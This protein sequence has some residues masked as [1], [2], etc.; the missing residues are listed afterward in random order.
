MAE[1][2]RGGEL[3]RLEECPLQVCR[4]KEHIWNGTSGLDQDQ[5][6]FIGVNESCK[7]L[8]LLTGK[9]GVLGGSKTSCYRA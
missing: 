6:A 2:A 3:L 9:L 8:D 7:S 1:Q 4:D 5:E